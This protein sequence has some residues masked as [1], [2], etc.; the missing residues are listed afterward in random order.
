MYAM[1]SEISDTNGVGKDST[2][3]VTGGVESLDSILALPLVGDD[4]VDDE[5]YT[6][7]G[8]TLESMETQNMHFGDSAILGPKADQILGESF[9]RFKT[10]FRNL[11]QR[12]LYLKK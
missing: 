4:E 7:V 2:E 12:D 5:G 1:A 11:I 8:S 6:D 10:P 3:V 9:K